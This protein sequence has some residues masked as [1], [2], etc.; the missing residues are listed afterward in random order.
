[1]PWVCALPL[2]ADLTAA[3]TGLRYRPD[4]LSKTIGVL[5]SYSHSEDL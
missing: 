4:I 2:R 5:K 3:S 1:M